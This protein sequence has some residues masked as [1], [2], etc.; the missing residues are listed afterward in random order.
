MDRLSKR[1]RSAL[2]SGIR[3]KDTRPEKVVRSVLH[4]LG[5]RFRLHRKQ[6]PGKP[7]IV[8][9]RWSAVV[10]VHGCF[11]HGCAS[12][13]RGTRI[14][15]TNRDF[16]LAKIAEKRARDARDKAA[17]EAAGWRVIVVWGCETDNPEKLA[18]SLERR[19]R[20]S[21]TPQAGNLSPGR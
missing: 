4:Q 9:P 11:W 3:T 8:L 10:F 6:L 2:M 7:D 19:L 18:F 16:W 1:E 15:K 5:F 12:C 14:P 13:D 21:D 17:L 20:G